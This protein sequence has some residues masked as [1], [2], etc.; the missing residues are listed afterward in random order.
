M[1][2]EL[3]LTT[4]RLVP[5]P[6]TAAALRLTASQPHVQTLKDTKKKLPSYPGIKHYHRGVPQSRLSKTLIVFIY[7]FRQASIFASQWSDS[8]NRPLHEFPPSASFAAPPGLFS[9]NSQQCYSS[10]PARDCV[11]PPC[12]LDLNWLYSS[13]YKHPFFFYPGLVCAPIFELFLL[14]ETIG[15]ITTLKRLLERSLSG[16]YKQ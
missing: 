6:N 8:S 5:E 15:W 9:V 14:H 11:L 16:V 2:E 3:H 1:V 12:S 4:A 10:R 13:R 7:L